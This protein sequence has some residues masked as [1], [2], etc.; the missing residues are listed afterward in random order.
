M[1]LS[2]ANKSG[3]TNNCDSVK[4]NNALVTINSLT[5]LLIYKINESKLINLKFKNSTLGNTSYK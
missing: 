3:I 4:D 1:N 5:R 2:V